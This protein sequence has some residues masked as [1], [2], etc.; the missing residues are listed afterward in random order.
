MIQPHSTNT[1]LGMKHTKYT[2]TTE[3]TSGRITGA[4]SNA[5]TAWVNLSKFSATVC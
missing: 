1:F 5:I 2:N 4:S 3:W